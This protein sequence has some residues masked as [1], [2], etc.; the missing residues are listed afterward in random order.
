MPIMI[1]TLLKAADLSTADVRL[2]RYKDRRAAKGRSSYE[3]LKSCNQ[4][5]FCG[6]PEFLV[7]GG[8]KAHDQ[9]RQAVPVPQVVSRHV[10]T[11]HPIAVRGGITRRSQISAI[12]VLLALFSAASGWGAPAAQ[13]A[14][15]PW[16]SAK[17]P[18]LVDA[19]NRMV[20]LRGVSLGGWLVEEMW[21]QPIITL[22]P[23]GSDLPVI[24]DHVSLN[25]VL[26][27]RLGEP[28]RRRVQTAMRDAWT[29]ETDFDRIRE[30]GFNHLRLPFLYDLIEE[31][32]GLAWLDRAIAWAGKRSL[33]VVLDLHGAPGGQSTEHHTGEEGRNQF[34]KN[35]ADIERAERVWQTIARRYRDRPEVAAYDLLNEPMGA[36]DLA[37]LYL[38]QGRL[39]RAIRAVDTKHVII[40]EDGYTGLDHMPVPAVAGW[41]NVV[42][43]CH[44]YAFNAKSE[45]GQVK[46]G[47]GHV[48]Y[49]R[50]HQGRLNCPL[51]LGEFNQEPHGTPQSLAALAK[52]LDR[53]GWSWA[54]WT[55]KV[56]FTG[57]TR[58]M[59]GLYHNPPKADALDPYRDSEDRLISK[60]RQM[61][62]ERLER[63][64]GLIESLSVPSGRK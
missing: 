35:P 61:R 51:Y 55:Y 6:G 36:G 39:Y 7:L 53:H 34:F 10:Q 37:T 26:G 44:H 4:L 33:Y 3:L 49:M 43:S 23:P 25:K 30:A 11:L 54:I 19:S 56:V 60:C 64:P 22:P 24:R 45:E 20:V 28:S 18:N 57:G 2:L 32:G 13:G 15:L 42:A 41:Q 5:V 17:G 8:V 16:L 29:N 58:S 50:R 46:A 31:P 40:I 21:M 59:W 9:S 48:E 52:D 62:T 47:Q 63:F 27:R 12:L 14:D 1:N 38:V